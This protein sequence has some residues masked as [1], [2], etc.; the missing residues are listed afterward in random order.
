MSGNLISKR[1]GTSWTC[2]N[3]ASH[4][5][6]LRRCPDKRTEY[7]RLT[8][9]SRR[10][11]DN[12]KN[13]KRYHELYKNDPVMTEKRRE[14]W[15]EFAKKKGKAWSKERSRKRPKT[16][17]STASLSESQLSKKREA[18]REW[19]KSNWEKRVIYAQKYRRRSPGFGF[20][21]L[22]A[23]ARRSGDIG[24]LAEECLA[25]IVRLDEAGGC[26]RREP[27]DRLGGLQVRDRDPSDAETESRDSA[28]SVM[29]SAESSTLKGKC[30]ECQTEFSLVALSTP[31]KDRVTL[32]SWCRKC[33]GDVLESTP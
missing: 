2:P 21:N 28:V 12:E 19:A 16:K 13:R 32:P 31:E 18:Y 11:R 23:E 29:S 25:A 20:R 6:S 27:K 4:N 9:L 22:I 7:R 8:H 10:E 33:G 17:A 14:S 3:R 30:I 24:K 15:R 26:G 5:C 1:L